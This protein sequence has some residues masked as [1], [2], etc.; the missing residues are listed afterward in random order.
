MVAVSAG[1]GY[2]VGLK[3]NGRV[4]AIGNNYEGQCDVKGWTDIVAVS[5]GW[6]HTVGLKSDGRVVAVGDNAWKQC[7]VDGW[8]NVKLPDNK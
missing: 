8:K 3:S 1:L 5:A 4:V 2:T 6:D 7:D